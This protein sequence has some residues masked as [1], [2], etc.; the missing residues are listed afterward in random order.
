MRSMDAMTWL[1]LEAAR[2]R[3]VVLGD[4]EDARR[5]RRDGAMTLRD[6]ARRDL[7]WLA[8]SVAAIVNSLPLARG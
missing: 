8:A 5:L 3:E 7:A 4:R 1:E 6:E 2:R